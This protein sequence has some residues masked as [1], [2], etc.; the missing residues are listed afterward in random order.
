MISDP[1]SMDGAGVSGRWRRAAAR[2]LGGQDAGWALP[3]FLTLFV[4]AWSACLIVAYAG[5]GLHYDVFEAFA[6]GRD[7]AWGY[8]KHP[9]LPSWA[10]R[11]WTTFMPATDAPVYVLAILNAA[12]GLFFIDRLARRYLAGDARCVALLLVTFIPGYHFLAAVFNHNVV[13]L[14]LWP[15]ATWCFLRSF[16]TRSP[17]WA[18]AAGATAAL[19]LYGKYY[20]GVLIVAFIVAALA[21]PDRLRYLCSPAP[22]VSALAGLA[23]LAPHLA[24]LAQSPDSPFDYAVGAHQQASRWIAA[25]QAAEFM[26]GALAYSVVPVALWL[27]ACRASMRRLATDVFGRMSPERRMLLH[28][29]FVTLGLPPLVGIVLGTKTVALWALP[30]VF[31]PLLFVLSAPGLKLA[32][33]RA[34]ELVA[35]TA[36]FWLVALAGAPLHAW[37]Q[38]DRLAATHFR[39]YAQQVADEMVRRWQAATPEPLNTLA[40][41]THLNW[42]IAYYHTPHPRV[43]DL[44]A[45]PGET[46]PESLRVTLRGGAASVCAVGHSDCDRQTLLERLPQARVVTFDVTLDRRGGAWPP[47]AFRAVILP[48]AP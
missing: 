30:G 21:H 5:L 38:G 29:G 44:P 6:L 40:G 4:L 45:E 37:L 11:A 26:L 35:V 24:W 3:V 36:A 46:L 15:L 14:W 28:L 7:L 10:M 31:L 8:A 27:M 47:M 34:E 20:S 39:P 18:L 19:A 12:A 17:G 16:D 32:R 22:W 33:P 43:V 42:A 48:P 25:R 1:G 23:V 9:P 13:L 2:W 41:A